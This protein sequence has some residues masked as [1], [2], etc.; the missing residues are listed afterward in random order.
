M[1]G[2]ILHGPRRRASGGFT[3]VEVLVALMVMAIMSLMAWQGVDSVVRTR[4]ISQQRVEQTLRLQTIVAQWEQD[5]AALR[6]TPAVPA[7]TCDGGAAR[8]V[9]ATDG[10]LQVVVWSLQPG[11][12]GAG[13]TWQRWASGPTVT[14]GTLQEAWLRTQQFQGQEAGQLKALTGIRSWNLYFFQ[15]NAWANCQSSGDVAGAASGAAGGGAALGS[16]R[17]VLPG[18]VRLVLAFEPASGFSGELV[19]DVQLNR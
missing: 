3:L 12:P 6:D 16:V 5:L 14:T 4:E 7:I 1:P 17:Q 10:G 8:L 15:G 9:R 18:G 13:S 2:P 19:R 11:G